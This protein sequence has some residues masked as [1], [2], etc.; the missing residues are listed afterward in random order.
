MWRFEDAGKLQRVSAGGWIERLVEVL[1]ERAEEREESGSSGKK[2][3]GRADAFE[4]DVA[5]GGFDDRTEQALVG[6]RDGLGV[7]WAGGEEEGA[8][9]FEGGDGEASEGLAGGLSDIR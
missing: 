9:D 5:L 4:E 7:H 2:G 6:D 1:A 3:G 8:E